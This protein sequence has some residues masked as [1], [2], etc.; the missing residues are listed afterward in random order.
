MLN[1]FKFRPAKPTRPDVAVAKPVSRR[2]SLSSLLREVLR[3]DG[4]PE[5]A[6]R[7]EAKIAA[8][9]ASQKLRVGAKLA[10]AKRRVIETATKLSALVDTETAE[11][12]RNSSMKRKA[13][14]AESPSPAK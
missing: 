4:V 3:P 10:D 12:L 6:H 7:S 9:A 5:Q 11:S 1:F 8:Q 13:M 2:A 14:F